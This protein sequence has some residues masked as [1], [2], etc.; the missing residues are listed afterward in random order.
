M[1]L[2][3]T[4]GRQDSVTLQE[5]LLVSSQALSHASDV[6]KERRQENTAE[7]SLSSPD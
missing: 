2:E 4:L 1:D 5:L 3:V 7:E 6:S